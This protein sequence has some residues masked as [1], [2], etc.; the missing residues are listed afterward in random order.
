MT[1]R[2]FRKFRIKTVLLMAISALTC[3]V[4][5]AS[6]ITIL[7]DLQERYPLMVAGIAAL[8]SVPIMLTIG[9][10][11]AYIRYRKKGAH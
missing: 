1:K 6:Y 2:A 10:I 9:Y 4:V 7:Q 5:C 11:V 8:P 3:L